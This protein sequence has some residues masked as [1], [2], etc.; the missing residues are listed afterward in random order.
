[1]E[2]ILLVL[3]HKINCEDN[4]YVNKHLLNNSNNVKIPR[5]AIS[6]SLEESNCLCVLL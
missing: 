6:V 3:P 2:V 5:T 4:I 1:M